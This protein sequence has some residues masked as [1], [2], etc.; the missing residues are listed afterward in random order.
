MGQNHTTSR[1][2]ETN[3]GGVCSAFD[4]HCYCTTTIN[5]I[6]IQRDTNVTPPSKRNQTRQE[7]ESPQDDALRRGLLQAGGVEIL[8]S[9]GELLL[10]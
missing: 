9:E 4:L 6:H 2:D 7:F 10:L 1:T 5:Y 3:F 8:E